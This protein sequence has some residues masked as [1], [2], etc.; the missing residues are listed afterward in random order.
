MTF[1]PLQYDC[2]KVKTLKT[3][4][5]KTIAKG[6]PLK[7]TTGLCELADGGD[8]VR[9]VALESVTDTSANDPLLAL[10][11]GGIEF[12]ATTRANTAQEQVDLVFGL[13]SDGTVENTKSGTYTAGDVFLVTQIVGAAA[14]KKVRGYFLDRKEAV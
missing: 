5:S 3:G 13:H 11:V 8:E 2:G 9:F 10:Y 12:E 6:D 1:T 4:A 14:D 7:F